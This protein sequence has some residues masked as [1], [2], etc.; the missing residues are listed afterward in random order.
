[1]SQFK[2]SSSNQIF[3]LSESNNTDVKG[4]SQHKKSNKFSSDKRN[5]FLWNLLLQEAEVNKSA[6]GLK[7]L[8]TNI[9][10]TLIHLKTIQF[11]WYLL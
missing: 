6:T 1:M 11:I 3:L 9:K 4:H 10:G 5:S 8:D 2:D 7:V